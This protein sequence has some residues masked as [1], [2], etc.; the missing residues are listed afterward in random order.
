MMQWNTCPLNQNYCDYHLG[1]NGRRRRAGRLSLLV[2]DKVWLIRR[3]VL[4]KRN[5]P[6][7]TGSLRKS[8]ASVKVAWKRVCRK[9]KRG[10]RRR[11]SVSNGPR[12]AYKNA[13][14]V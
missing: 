8:C 3:I 5:R 2:E 13:P 12:R 7:K 6:K 10:G 11:W 14:L 4:K 9:H 1:Q